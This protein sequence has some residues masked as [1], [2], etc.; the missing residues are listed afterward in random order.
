ML[1]RL[2]EEEREEYIRKRK[3]DKAKYGLEYKVDEEELKENSWKSE[4][5]WTLNEVPPRFRKELFSGKIPKTFKNEFLSSLSDVIRE[6]FKN[7]LGNGVIPRILLN[8]LKPKRSINEDDGDEDKDGYDGPLTA[9]LNFEK[10]PMKIKKQFFRGKCPS[11]AKF[12]LCNYFPDQCNELKKGNL[13]MS[14]LQRLMGL[15]SEEEFEE[16]LRELRNK[17]NEK[18][19]L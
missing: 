7:D 1:H 17:Y 12:T 2:S 16:R 13:P 18:D 11:K 14:V 10:I 6:R 8:E 3:E 9:R 5:T 19:E 15:G 4:I